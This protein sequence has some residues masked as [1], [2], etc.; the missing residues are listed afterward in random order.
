MLREFVGCRIHGAVSLKSF[1]EFLKNLFFCFL[2]SAHVRVLTSIVAL[3]DVI[4][5]DVAIL[6]EVKLLE[7]ALDE[8]L[9]ERTHV[10]LDCVQQLVK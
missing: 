5:V 6:I 10:S 8:V 9:P 7:D 1:E 4:D 3:S 2:A